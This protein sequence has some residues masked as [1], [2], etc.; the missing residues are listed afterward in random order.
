ML[1]FELFCD[2]IYTFTK[3]T[4]EFASTY[5]LAQSAILVRPSVNQLKV[6]RSNDIVS[7]FHPLTGLPLPLSMCSLSTVPGRL[8]Y[9]PFQIPHCAFLQ[10]I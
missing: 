9:I 5:R 3:S 2:S 10:L 8:P 6:L 4:L 1:A 7:L